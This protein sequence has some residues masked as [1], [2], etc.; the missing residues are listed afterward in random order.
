MSVFTDD[1]LA[2]RE[3][4]DSR[5]PADRILTLGSRVTCN[6]DGGGEV[7]SARVGLHS[8]VGNDGA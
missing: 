7:P 5:E 2:G 6:G 4:N 1:V 3:V 8:G